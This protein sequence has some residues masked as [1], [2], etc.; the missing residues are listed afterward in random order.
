LTGGCQAVD[1]GSLDVSGKSDELLKIDVSYKCQ[2]L[3]NDTS[4]TP[5]SNF[6]IPV[7]FFIKL[8]PGYEQLDL[9]VDSAVGAAAFQPVGSFVVLDQELANFKLSMALRSLQAY[10]VFGSGFPTWPR[11][12]P[13]VM[14]HSSGKYFL[15][16]D[17]S[18]IPNG[19]QSTQ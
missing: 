8:V 14:M 13:D 12:A 17:A 9:I 7:S 11:D 4:R 15:L 3:T 5:I 10:K 1:D 18:Q 19:K 16:F 6:I 2:I